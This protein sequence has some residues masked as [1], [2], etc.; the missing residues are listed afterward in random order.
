MPH[1][2]TDVKQ[3]IFNVRC[4]GVWNKLPC[5]VVESGSLSAFKQSLTEFL[6]DALFEY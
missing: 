5:E 4:I 6:G 2:Y 1:Y 3:R